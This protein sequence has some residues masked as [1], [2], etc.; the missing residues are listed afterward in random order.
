MPDRSDNC[1]VC[2]S[3][4]HESCGMSKMSH[5]AIDCPRNASA[6]DSRFDD[7]KEM[8]L[9]EMPMTVFS[10]SGDEVFESA[11][12]IMKADDEKKQRRGSQAVPGHPDDKRGTTQ[13]ELDEQDRVLEE[14]GMDS[15]FGIDDRFEEPVEPSAFFID[16][17]RDL[18]MQGMPVMQAVSQV[19]RL[20]G[21]SGRQLMLAYVKAYR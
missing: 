14:G 11:W 10:L 2:G 4:P 13:E 3:N 19:A 6:W 15:R 1:Q 7:A 18:V 21:V 17:V 9:G 16:D 8:R 12:S 5:D 20:V